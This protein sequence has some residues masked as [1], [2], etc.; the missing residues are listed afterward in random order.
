CRQRPNQGLHD[1]KRVRQ[2]IEIGVPAEWS[3]LFG[4]TLDDMRRRRL[5]GDVGQEREAH[6]AHSRLMHPAKAVNRDF[7]S[8]ARH[9][10]S[11]AFHMLEC[12]YDHTVIVSMACRLNSHKSEE[13]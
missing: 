5:A 11:A 7:F 8:H 1:L 4:N 9:T 6:A 3:D 10:R 2:E 13:S 12:V